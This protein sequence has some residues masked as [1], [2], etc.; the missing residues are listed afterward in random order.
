ME[1][2]STQS[3]LTKST[4]NIRWTDVWTSA[5]ASGCA[6]NFFI[7][8]RGCG[9]TYSTLGSHLEN[10]D[11]IGKLLYLRLTQAELDQVATV[12]ECP[13]NQLNIDRDINVEFL[14]VKKSYRI[15]DVERDSDGKI[16][17]EKRIG[18]ARAISTFAN[19]RGGAL[20]GVGVIYVDEFLPTERVRKTPEIKRAGYL[21]AHAYETIAR[22]REIMGLP[23][24]PVIFTA[25]A[26][27][28]DS[29]ILRAFGLI[30]VI[31][32]MQEKGQ[33]RYT[34]VDESIYVELID[35]VDVSERKKNS[36]IY[37][38]IKDRDFQRTAL[39][40]HFEDYALTLVRKKV[41]INEYV[42][43]V[44]LFFDKEITI[45]QHKSNGTLHVAQR[46][47]TAKE[48][49]TAS[50]IKAFSLHYKHILKPR[51][52]ERTVTFDSAE[53]YYYIMELLG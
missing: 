19:M 5:R 22:N 27:A 53:T 16:L 40:T 14:P 48:R 1:K 25:N 12:D 45:Y 47:D 31:Q 28:L 36:V 52:V 41:Q 33:K 29:D 2:N 30:K 13:Y 21:F 24:L 4:H 6:F 10:M 20:P 18:H 23:F 38:A 39:E 50:S 8:G 37:R 46:S 43:L 3:N 32:N 11:Y 51:A 44:N 42:P 34:N 49:Y 15:S 9:K 26:F 35:N 17:S 7:G